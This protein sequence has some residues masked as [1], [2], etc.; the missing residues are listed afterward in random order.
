MM[1][2]EFVD[3]HPCPI[4][5]CPEQEVPYALL[6][7]RR[8]WAQVPGDVKAQVYHYWHKGHPRPGYACVRDLAIELVRE[9]QCSR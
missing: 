7:C 8:H 6:M 9:K 4:E 3:T 2:D 5:G 1:D